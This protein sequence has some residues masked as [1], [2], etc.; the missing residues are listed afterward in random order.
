LTTAL[1]IGYKR[2]LTRMSNAPSSPDHV[3]AAEP[4]LLRPIER[5]YETS[6]FVRECCL[7]PGRAVGDEPPRHLVVVPD[8]AALRARRTVGIR[9]VLRFELETCGVVLA[10]EHRITGFDVSRL[11]LARAAGGIDR[12]EVQRWWQRE[13]HEKPEGERR[14]P[15]PGDGLVSR[16][17]E[18]VAARR[19]GVALDERTHLDLDLNLES[20]ERVELFFDVERTEGVVLDTERTWEIA[21]FGDL[22]DAVH[23]AA[24][25]GRTRSDTPDDRWQ[26][27]LATPP[28]PV[29]LAELRR[30]KRVRLEAFIWLVKLLGLLARLT[31]GLRTSG[32]ER[33][34][35]GG[36]LIVAPNHQTVLDGFLVCSALPPRLL[37]SI[38]IVGAP[39]YFSTPLLSWLARSAN[40]IPVDP[41][42]NLLTALR[43]GAAGLR[44]GRVLLL[45]PEGER[46][47]DGEVARFRRGVTVLASR[48]RVP[49]VPVAL[50]GAYPIWPRG[51]GIDW[52]RVRPFGGHRTHIVF[53][54]AVR[55]GVADAPAG[56]AALARYLEQVVREMVAE[57]RR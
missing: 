42:A 5:Q 35:A 12:L 33:L 7:I 20:L 46:T 37:R 9:D 45:F 16:L 43:L 39:E 15:S 32:R 17:S 23:S 6:A 8:E 19:P 2:S 11:P 18:L 55:A 50:D 41:D 29:A 49:V 27:L 25:S 30:S 13:R 53:G 52:R 21:T 22:V 54:P 48:L 14:P 40:L 4:D 24:P 57:M 1:A 3:D 47:L 56:D 10:A 36:P 44:D 38:F 51:R 28:G 34:P 31:I 26:A